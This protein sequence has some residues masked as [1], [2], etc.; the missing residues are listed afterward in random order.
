M[1]HFGAAPELICIPTTIAWLYNGQDPVM[2]QKRLPNELGPSPAGLRAFREEWVGV[3]V[4]STYNWYGL[5][6]TGHRVH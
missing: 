1:H 3:V 6:E 2:Y 4:E 5:M